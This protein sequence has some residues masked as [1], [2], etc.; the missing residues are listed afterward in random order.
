MTNRIAY[1]TNVHAGADLAT[2]IANLETHA[3]R[4]R[5]LVAPRATLG[6][7]LWLSDAAAA[8][9][10]VRDDVRRLRDRLDALGLAVVTMN[11]FPFGD[12]H[13]A[14]V[15]HA[16]YEPHWAQ[17]SRLVY[18]LRLAEILSDLVPPGTAHASIST[19]PI[20]WRSTFSADSCGGSVGLAISH[21]EGAAHGLARIEAERGV[22]ITVDVEPEPGCLLDRSQHVV[23]LF[24]QSLHSDVARRYLGVCHDICHAAVMFESQAE[25]LAIYH[26]AGIRVNKVQVSSAIECDGSDAA[27]QA[28]SKFAEPRY[29]HQT[30]VSD[31]RG[32][33]R[34]FEDLPDAIAARPR[35]TW[36]THFHVPIHL[37]TLDS[38]GTTQREIRACLAALGHERPTLEI[39][40][41]AWTVL[42]ESLRPARLADGIADE[43]RWLTGAIA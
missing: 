24:E 40:T 8:E 28:L 12:F 22:R 26:R 38:L 29:L 37:L 3:A 25:A 36:R 2:T 4:V 13:G 33:V 19:L 17:R 16:V 10:S 1:C 39:E 31:E 43:F 11:G 15:K 30:C 35:G 32:D 9:L 18:T 23:D 34:F 20:G 41:Y 7:G 5:E 6:I 21:L 27:V 42:P 14:C